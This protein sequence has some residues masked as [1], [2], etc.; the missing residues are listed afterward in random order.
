MIGRSVE[1]N[2]IVLLKMTERPNKN[3]ATASLRF[4]TGDNKYAQDDDQKKIIFIVHGLNVMGMKRLPCL[5]EE[6][7]FL[8]LVKM[9]TDYLNAFDIY[10]IPM[11]NPDG[12]EQIIVRIFCL[13]PNLLLVFI[14]FI[15]LLY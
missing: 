7:A 5:Y 9:Y 12:F 4:K 1:Y 6:T 13:K 10:L 3:N 8:E 11:A 15:Y 14:T 2:D